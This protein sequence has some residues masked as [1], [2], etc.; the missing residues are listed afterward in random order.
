M[1]DLDKQCDDCSGGK[2]YY[3]V[4]KRE[5]VE[6]GFKC[7]ECNGTGYILTDLGKEFVE[8]L[9]RHKNEYSS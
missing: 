1:F 3:N 6:E 5:Y 9:K 2:R 4:V 8:F 7:N